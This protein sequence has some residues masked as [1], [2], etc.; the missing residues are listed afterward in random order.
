M[1]SRLLE[2]F[3]GIDL[4]SWKS[5]GFKN[6]RVKPPVVGRKAPPA[7]QNQLEDDNDLGANA[8]PFTELVGRDD[9]EEDPHMSGF[10]DSELESSDQDQD[11][12]NRPVHSRIQGAFTSVARKRSGSS[13]SRQQKAKQPRTSSSPAPSGRFK[14]RQPVVSPTPRSTPRSTPSISGSQQNSSP[15]AR[16]SSGKRPLSSMERLRQRHTGRGSPSSAPGKIPGKLTRDHRAARTPDHSTR[17]HGD[18][19]VNPSIKEECL[20]GRAM[21]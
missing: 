17:K 4:S 1:K 9:D 8:N 6:P 7:T 14:Q 20:V 13:S 12:N 2:K 5:P 19:F 21:H 16:T 11:E 15:S 3:P 10:S 18:R